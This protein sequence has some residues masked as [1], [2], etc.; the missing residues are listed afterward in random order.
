MLDPPRPEVASAIR[1]CRE[2]GIRTIMVTGDSGPTAEAIGRSIGLVAGAVH[3]ITGAELAELDDGELRNRLA[4]RDVIFARI[5]PEQKLRL[6]QLLREG[7]EVVAMTGDGVND[8]PA[9]KHADIGIAMGR[10]GTEVAKE[11]AELILIDDNFASIVAAVEE[12]R[13]CTTTSGASPAITSAPT[14][15]SSSPSS[16]GASPVARYRFRS[17][18][19]R[20]S[21]STSEP[22]WFRQSGS[23]P[24]V[25][26][27][28]RWHD[29]RARDPSDF[30]TALSSPGL[31]LDRPA[32]GPRGDGELPL[33]ICGR[34]VAAV[35]A[36]R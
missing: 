11:A 5:D 33:R 17:S 25:L 3:V 23:A 32:R 6:A 4:E 8:A 36:A 30:S 35:G 29:R 14:S 13:A 28:G 20:C 1:R 9:L 31:R 27:R 15:A 10:S 22:T 26:S 2:A 34:R 19:C 7:G 16:S 21:R 12:G 24:S 18:S